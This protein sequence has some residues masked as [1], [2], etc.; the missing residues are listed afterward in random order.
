MLGLSTECSKLA[1]APYSQITY[2]LFSQTNRR[3][4]DDCG[5]MTHH[6]IA[7]SFRREGGRNYGD[8]LSNRR[9]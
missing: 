5:I 7:A 4:L 3:E 1:P 8:D 2:L 9:H 6:V